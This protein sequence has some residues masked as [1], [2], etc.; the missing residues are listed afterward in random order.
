MRKW[1]A[2]GGSSGF[3]EAGRQY[4]IMPGRR[5][6][7]GVSGRLGASGMSCPISR[8]PPVRSAFVRIGAIPPA[9]GGLTG[10]TTGFAGKDEVT[11]H[12]TRHGC[13]V[14]P[15]PQGE[16]LAERMNPFPTG[17]DGGC[18]AVTPSPPRTSN[19]RPYGV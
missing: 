9:Q 3:W 7:R 17:L 2:G 13:A 11:V 4:I 6:M 19:A 15:S 10:G 8:C 5:W 16:G 1:T 18:R 12:H 14:L